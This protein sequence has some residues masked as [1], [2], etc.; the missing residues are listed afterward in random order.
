MKKDSEEMLN[1]TVC[2]AFVAYCSYYYYEK[3]ITIVKRNTIKKV[4]QKESMTHFDA[5]LIII[6]VIQ[7]NIQKRIRKRRGRRRR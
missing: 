2:A 4:N 6:I 3:N 7:S 5:S 1:T